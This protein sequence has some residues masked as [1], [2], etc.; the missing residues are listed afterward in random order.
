MASSAPLTEVDLFFV[1]PN[2]KKIDE[3][4]NAS[5]EEREHARHL[6]S[7]ADANGAQ[8]LWNF[9][10]SKKERV[11]YGTHAK[12]YVLQMCGTQS[13][14]KF[15]TDGPKP[16]LRFSPRFGAS[17][18]VMEIPPEAIPEGLTEAEMRKCIENLCKEV[19]AA[20]SEEVLRKTSSKMFVLNPAGKDRARWSPFMGHHH[21]HFFGVF[22]KK[23]VKVGQKAHYYIGVH[24]DS[25]FLGEALCAFAMHK[26]H[27]PKKLGQFVHC[28]EL[29]HVEEFADR[30]SRR[31]MALVCHSLGLHRH[32]LRFEDDSTALI[33]E[34]EH[35]AYPEMIHRDALVAH[36]RYNCFRKPHPSSS[37][38]VYYAGTTP[39]SEVA[40]DGR[41][42]V[43]Q[44]MGP[45][46]GISLY[47]VDAGRD[48]TKS[49][50]SYVESDGQTVRH[51]HDNRFSAFPVSMGRPRGNVESEQQAVLEKNASRMSEVYTW[52]DRIGA[53]LHPAFSA[54]NNAKTYE[55]GRNAFVLGEN[56]HEAV[57]L[58][59]VA[60]AI[61]R[62]NL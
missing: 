53:E 16:N 49:C 25:G 2:A 62:A 4:T 5:E 11:T 57:R 45:Q 3:L 50:V 54:Y 39:L 51:P 35:E 17:L 59:P 29:R 33:D 13:M 44:L 24:S 27:G 14:Q 43:A 38:V 19:D 20:S 37:A 60:V 21:G 9:E 42:Y 18:M 26:D 12:G 7:V 56:H 52:A 36:T 15:I 55:E 22:R 10:V 1:K 23:G 34:N 58:E 61:P 46:K 31:L 40:R 41:K 47:A 8:L 30:N 28:S 6:A 32:K 48:Y